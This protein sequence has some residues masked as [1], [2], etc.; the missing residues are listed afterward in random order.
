MKFIYPTIKAILLGI[1]AYF[2]N[3]NLEMWQTILI[4]L[5]A[6]LYYQNVVATLMGLHTIPIMDYTCFLG[7]SKS[8]VNFMNCTWYDTKC[9]PDLV[10]S[11][12]SW[13]VKHN[14]KLR[15]K[16]VD[17][18]GDFYYQEMTEEEMM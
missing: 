1:A 7:G 9:D 5:A 13:A 14:P 10:K 6:V 18:A 3:I 15:Y 8:V 17:V 2:M 16:I 12:I 4:C 11:K